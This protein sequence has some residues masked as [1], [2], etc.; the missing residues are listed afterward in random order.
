MIYSGV[1]S[2]EWESTD[3]AVLVRKGWDNRIVGY[4]WISPRIVKLIFKLL[5]YVITITDMY[6]PVEGKMSET[7]EFY[8]DL[9]VQGVYNRSCKN[10]Y[11]IFAGDFNAGVDAFTKHNNE[12]TFRRILATE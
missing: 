9:L 10:E 6:A 3:L 8:D 11:N 1:P 5:T 2:E 7:E 4:G 12:T